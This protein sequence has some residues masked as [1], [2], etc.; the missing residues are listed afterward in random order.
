[1]GKFKSKL[2]KNKMYNVQTVRWCKFFRSKLLETINWTGCRQ[3]LTVILKNSVKRWCWKAKLSTMLFLRRNSIVPCLQNLQEIGVHYNKKYEW[4]LFAG[5]V[6]SSWVPWR[7]QL[8]H[9]CY[10]KLK[11]GHN[12]TH[13][14]KKIYVTSESWTIDFHFDILRMTV[15]G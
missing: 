14:S 6:K 5:V 15:Y 10:G 3:T 2:Y 4:K 11:Y 13:H 8:Y 12:E 9:N 7:N 1:M